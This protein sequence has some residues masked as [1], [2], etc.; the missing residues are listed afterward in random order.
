MK[1]KMHS[2]LYM[3]SLLNSFKK[4]LKFVIFLYIDNR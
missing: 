2:I 1:F 3:I 4:Y